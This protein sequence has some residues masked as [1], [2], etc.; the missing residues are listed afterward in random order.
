MAYVLTWQLILPTEIVF[1]NHTTIKK[2]IW[3][4]GYYILPNSSTTLST[5]VILRK[6]VLA[7]F[8]SPTCYIRTFSVHKVRGNCHFLNH[9]PNPMSL[10]NIKIFPLKLWQNKKGR[11]F[12]MLAKMTSFLQLAMRKRHHFVEHDKQIFGLSYFV[13]ALAW[14]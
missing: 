2:V 6:G 10:C 14:L 9:L 1:F 12:V 13:R 11:I 3:R 4:C 8:E 5:I 7:F